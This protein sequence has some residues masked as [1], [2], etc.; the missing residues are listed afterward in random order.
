[1]EN[2]CKCLIC[3]QPVI[4]NRNCVTC[5]T[6]FCFDHLIQATVVDKKCPNCHTPFLT[7]DTVSN[8]DHRTKDLRH[9]ESQFLHNV[10]V[11]RIVN[12]MVCFCPLGCG[13]QVK[14]AN[15]ETHKKRVCT[16]AIVACVHEHLGIYFIW[17]THVS[18]CNSICRM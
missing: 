11:Q 16:N 6:L 12:E 9:F 1:M 3:K 5:H 2:Y 14:L 15:L 13:A 10:P 18:N 4:N 7:N 17:L 8:G